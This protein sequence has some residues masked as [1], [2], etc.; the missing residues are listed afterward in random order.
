MFM[1][2]TVVGRAP[3]WYLY[4]LFGGTVSV[5]PWILIAVMVVPA[6]IVIVGRLLRKESLL[7]ETTPAAEALAEGPVP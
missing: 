3:R 6:A 4:A 1:I 2:A 7:A 5:P